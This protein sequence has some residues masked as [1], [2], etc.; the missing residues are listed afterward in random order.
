M[1]RWKKYQKVMPKIKRSSNTNFLMIV[2]RGLCF[3]HIT[4]SPFPVETLSR[5]CQNYGFCEL[6]KPNL[7]Q[8]NDIFYWIS[9]KN[10]WIVSSHDIDCWGK[11]ACQTTHKNELEFD[12]CAVPWL[13]VILGI[14]IIK[15]PCRSRALFTPLDLQIYRNETND[16]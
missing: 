13:A 8:S 6:N 5:S 14:K 9:T 15:I 7:L 3:S 4:V 16:G 10:Y 2:R 11:Y 1:S 12:M